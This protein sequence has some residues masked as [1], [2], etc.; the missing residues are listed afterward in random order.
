MW[1]VLL[2]GIVTLSGL[3]APAPTAAQQVLDRIEIVETPTAVEIHVAF[4]TRIIYQRHTPSERGDLIRVFLD[5]PDLD[6]SRRFSRELAV[7]PPS[8]LLPKFTVTFPDQGTNGLSIKFSEAV[9]FRISQRDN[10]RNKLVISVKLDRPQMP[11]PPPPEVKVPSSPP[12]V[13]KGPEQS[14]DIPVFRPGMD[15]ETYAEDLMKLGHK[16]LI[17]GENEQALQIFNALLNLPPN[18][19]SQ[20]AQEWVGVARQRSREYVKA[21]AEYE[22]YLKLYPEGEDTVRVRQRLAELQEASNQLAQ[23][24]TG[25]VPRKIDE[26]RVYGSMYTYYYGGYSQTK[27]TDKVAN[28][29][30]NINRHDQSLL[31]SAFDVTGRYR[32]DE[33]DN[34]LVVRGSQS[35]DQLA[36]SDARRNV[37]RLRALYFEHSSQ[38]SYF[39]R[40]GRQPGNTGGV[41]DFRFDGAWVRYTPVPQF[42]SVN[43]LGGQPRQFSLTPNYVPDDP[44]NFRAD[45]DPYFYGANVDIGPIGQAWSGNVYYFNQ[46]VN[47]VVDRRA[48]GTEV[49]YGSNGKNLFALV[50]YDIYFD[51]LNIAT[52]NGTWVTEGT[53]F[54]FIADHRRT[55]YLRT[56]NALFGIQGASLANINTGNASL[57]REEALN[58]TATSDLFLAGVLHSVSTDWQLGGDVRLNRISGTPR[59]NCLVILPG[60]STVFINPNALT[61]ASCS[62]QALPGS[63]DIWTYTAQ[64]IGANFLFKNTTFVANASYSTS[65]AYRGE[66]LTLNLL[67]RPRQQLQFDTFVLLYHQKDSFN[68]ELYRVTPT[69]RIDYRFLDSW[70]FEATGGVEKT[71]TDSSTQK[72]STLRQ[73]FFF[74]LRWDFS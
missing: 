73:F 72:D 64:A 41:L 67:A 54:N 4:N 12:A 22:L 18:K 17:A 14:F 40:V 50:D 51:A 20:V 58:V 74:G 16:A 46:M 56:A 63:G 28:T 61:D 19:Q 34:K 13:A 65:P 29:T 26:T 71:R 3:L 11:P 35:Y 9:R 36:T 52:L 27:I 1:A 60:T 39:V 57:L 48:V 59:S 69:V 45:L 66:S 15:V 10:Q 2:C 42:L 55:P 53:T 31:Q 24:K 23:A 7:S 68:V 70:T 37:S 43:L 38:D 25:R 44:R 47:S 62:L 8:D 32:K 5:F 30:T 6:R 49:R 21:K 33:Y